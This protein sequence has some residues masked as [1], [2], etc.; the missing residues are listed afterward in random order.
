MKL[1]WAGRWT[2]LLDLQSERDFWLSSSQLKITCLA[3]LARKLNDCL[4]RI[5]G[6]HLRVQESARDAHFIKIATK[7]RAAWF[8]EWLA[9]LEPIWS[10][11]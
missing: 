2:A 4:V 7:T 5:Q 10:R 1:S 8:D 9:E 6:R 3:E 11:L